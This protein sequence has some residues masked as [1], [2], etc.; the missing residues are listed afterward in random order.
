MK[1]LFIVVL[2][3]GTLLSAQNVWI[4]ELH[5]DNAGTDEGEFIEIIL[6]DTGS[7]TL[8][9][10]TL[11]QYNGNGGASYGTHTLDSFTTGSVIDNFTIYYKLIAGIQNGAPDGI[12]IDYQGTLITGQFLSYEGTFEAVDGPAN[13][14][15]ST[16]IGVVE[17]SSTLIGESL[18]LLG[19]GAV[20]SDFIWQDPAPETPGELNIGQ[21]LGG[22]P[23]PTIIVVSPNGGEQWEQGSTHPITWTSI[24]FTD[25]VKI[26]LGMIYERT[27]EILIASTENDGEWEWDIPID[28]SISDGYVIIISDAIDGDPSDQSNDPFSIIEPIPVTPY[29]IYEIQYSVTGP[30]PHVGELV[31]TSGI[32][33]AKFEN[34]FFIQDGVGA[35]NGIVIYPLQ[36]VVVGD[37]IIISG[38]V[39]EYNDKTEIT[40]IINM[41]I[42]GS[43][44]L[45]NPI[46]ID[47]ATL[48]STEDYESVLTKIQNVTVSNEDLGY[49]NWEVEDQSGT[50]IIGGLGNYTYEPLLGQ[51][52]FNLTGVVDYTYGDFKLEP[53]DDTDIDLVGTDAEE[54]ISTMKLN[55]LGNYP[56]PFNPTTTIYFEL[57]T[58]NTENAELIIYNLK[59]QKVK[60]FPMNQ[61]TNSPVHQVIWNGT[62][63]S[64]KPVTTGVYLYKLKAGDKTYT[65][66]MLLLK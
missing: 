14:V 12:A 18:Q 27:R 26:E 42:L 59:G 30:S 40:D 65:K 41:T 51:L 28:Q 61:F 53:R 57:N 7:Y 58:E 46:V 32:V 23:E 10:F 48:S 47:A 9:D 38:T 39:L 60:S 63:E 49:G 4:N 56:N 55:S 66:K 13:G 62:D 29:T 5:Y 54:D 36:E 16:D 44:D 17:G 20:Y 33:T 19:S 31:E 45:P 37:E 11:T 43:A 22:T 2:F 25:N 34:Y 1:K 35:W 8:S 64:G 3:L 24:N 15:M 6:E 21:T 52:I 50:C